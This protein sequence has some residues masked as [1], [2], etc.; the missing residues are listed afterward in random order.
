MLSFR[1]VGRRA[2]YGRFDLDTL[3]KRR[4]MFKG[5]GAA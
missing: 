5:E 1:E 3:P 2:Y 4:I